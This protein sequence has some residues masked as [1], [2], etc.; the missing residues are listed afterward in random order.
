MRHPIV[1]ISWVIW[2]GL[3]L[4]IGLYAALGIF[5]LKPEAATDAVPVLT[6]VLYGTAAFNVLI[7][8]IIRFFL[9]RS[10]RKGGNW[11]GRYLAFAI[12]I[13]AMTEA[14]AIYGFVLF[15]IGGALSTFLIFT[16]VAAG[17]LL[18]H[19]PLCLIPRP[20]EVIGPLGNRN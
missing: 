19:M 18:W 2:G 7:T 16:G 6:T 17:L 9:K 13:W 4:C 1:L 3:L 15:L 8:V 10:L 5:V 14:I 12:M 20:D 11:A